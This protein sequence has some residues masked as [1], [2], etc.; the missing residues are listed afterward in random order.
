ME[1]LRK[2][3]EEIL[4]LKQNE[5]TQKS[6][7]VRKVMHDLQVYQ[8][9]LEL[10]NLELQENSE[11]LKNAERKFYSLFNFSPVAYFLLDK[12][13]VIQESNLKAIDLLKSERM[14]LINKPIISFIAERGMTDL[15]DFL[16]NTLQSKLLNTQE[17]SFYTKNRNVISVEIIAQH[18]YDENILLAAIDITERKL[19]D[20]QLRFALKK[21]EES[22][23]LKTN[24]LNLISHE[25][26]TPLNA[27]IGFSN[28]LKNEK[29]SHDKKEIFAENIT[30][31]SN[32]L[33]AIVEDILLISNPENNINTL[34]LQNYSINEFLNDLKN[35]FSQKFIHSQN[36]FDFIFLKNDYV[37]GTDF[38]KLKNVIER[39]VDNAERHTKNGKIEICAAVEANY[40]TFTVKD[41][42]CG[43][44]ENTRSKLFKP[45]EKK[46]DEQKFHSGM[47]LGLAIAKKYCDI[48]SGS[49]FYKPN[50]TAGSVF[51]VELPQQTINIL[52]NNNTPVKIVSK[53]D[54]KKTILI[55]EDEIINFQLLEEILFDLD[56][57]IIHAE[58]GRIAVE[59]FLQYE[60]DLILMDFKMPEMDGIEA[61][62][63]IRKV[64]LQVPIIAVTAF[65]N[66]EKD[67]LV[68]FND[69]LNK[70]IDISTALDTVSKFL[71]E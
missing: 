61:T 13:G 44:D 65:K 6:E 30:K 8:I 39:L 17:F 3:A 53:K 11:K 50:D 35:H 23:K 28:I 41:N 47:G 70:P 40:V 32:Q 67:V 18:I 55:A 62:K 9:E 48:L 37:F 25:I 19:K 43:I 56:V 31:A 54:T 66:N 69:L 59:M 68:L 15:F 58:N 21:A 42:G 22:D 52:E 5:F 12:K 51:V 10:Q 4:H 38:S 46:E 64:N 71:N 7:D 1:E 45:F 63:I 16:T 14:H 34:H 29:S 2:K 24:F 20:E 36:I 26:R 49:I 33:L 27:I 60:P 57:N